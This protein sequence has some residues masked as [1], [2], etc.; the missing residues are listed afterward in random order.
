MRSYERRV[1]VTGSSDLDGELQTAVTVHLPDAITG[2]ATILFGWPGGGF[3]R[4]YFDVQA[5]PGYSQAAFHTDPETCSSRVTTWRPVT[6]RT[7]RTC[8]R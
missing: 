6:A 3:G 8:C 5:V 2:P 7:P 4:R 1:D